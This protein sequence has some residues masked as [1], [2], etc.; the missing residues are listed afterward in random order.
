MKHLLRRRIEESGLGK[1]KNQMTIGENIKRIRQ[2]RG[3]TQEELGALIGISG[4]MVRKYELGMANPRAERLKALAFGLGV[5]VEVLKVEEIDSVTAMHRLFQLFCKYGG[6]FDR[7][8]NLSF[9]KLDI[10]P[11]YQR[12]MLY[13]EELKVAERISGEKDRESAIKNAEK[14]FVCWIYQNLY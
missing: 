1:G 10:Q 2:Q 11:L 8:E 13:Q 4:T 5:H 7:S 6:S 12:W 14:E 3:L 9:E